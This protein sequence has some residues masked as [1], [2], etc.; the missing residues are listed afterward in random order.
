MLPFHT[1]NSG[2]TLQKMLFIFTLN[3]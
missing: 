1:V 3:L 2:F